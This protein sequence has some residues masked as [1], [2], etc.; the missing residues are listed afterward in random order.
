MTLAN[1][2][3]LDKRLCR[4]V[5]AIYDSELENKK[6]QPFRSKELAISLVEPNFKM[7]DAASLPHSSFFESEYC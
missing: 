1:V 3:K 5:K 2:K 4:Q 7:K 6:T